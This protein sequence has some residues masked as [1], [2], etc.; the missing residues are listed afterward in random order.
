MD[1]KIGIITPDRGDRP[2]LLNQWRYLLLNQ[3]LKPNYIILVD[4][5]LLEPSGEVDITKRYRIGYDLLRNKGLDLIA[6]IENDDFYAPTYL[7]YWANKWIEKGKP[8]LLG[9]DFTY[10]YHLKLKKYFKFNHEQRSSMMNTFMKPDMTFEWCADNE[11]Y[12]DMHLWNYAVMAGFFGGPSP[13]KGCIVQP[14]ILSIGMKHGVGLCGGLGH[15]SQSRIVNGQLANDRLNRY[16]H[17]DNGFL[18]AN[19]DPESFKFYTDY[20]ASLPEIK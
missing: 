7:E 3:T 9:S 17:E 1:I 13:F 18:Q 2:E 11:P 14:P 12:T 20:S 4:H 5:K 8:D 19:V 6:Y 16:V 10:Y 15:N